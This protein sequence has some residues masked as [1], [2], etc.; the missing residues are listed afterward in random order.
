MLNSMKAVQ[1]TGHVHAR[2]TPHGFWRFAANY[3][4]AARA[5]ETK[6]H[7][8]G[9]LFFPT[10]QLYGIAIELSLKAF[11]LKRG[12]SLA[13]LRALSHNLTKALALARRHK[14]GREV[15]LHPRELAAIHVLDINYSTNRLRYIV[16]GATQVP[17][18]VYVERAAKELVLG[19]E[20]LCTGVQGRLAHAV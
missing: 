11:L 12:R 17:Q 15:K 19:L 1:S 20:L 6:I 3:L 2:S 10:L 8:E 13:E 18:L 5:L 14:L 16:S 4:L 7:V 9:Q